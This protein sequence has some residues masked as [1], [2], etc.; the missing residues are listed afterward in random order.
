MAVSNVNVKA[1]R[2]GLLLEH[3]DPDEFW[4]REDGRGYCRVVGHDRS[5]FQHVGC[6][7]L[8]LEHGYRCQWHA[9]SVRGIASR[10][11]MRVRGALQVACDTDAPG[12]IGNATGFKVHTCEV[13]SA[14]CTVDDEVG[15]DR[16]CLPR[17]L[18]RDPKS[19]KDLHHAG[20]RCATPDG[21]TGGCTA[22]QKTFV[23][24]GIKFFQWGVAAVDNHGGASRTC[25]DVR[26]FEGHEAT[27]DERD[28]GWQGGEIQKA[29]AV[30]EVLMT[31]E[32]K[33]ARPG[34]G[35]DEEFARLIGPAIDVDV[36][37][38]CECRH[39]MKCG[40]AVGAKVFFHV[41]RNGVGEAVFVLH[42]VGPVDAEL[43]A[44]DAFTGE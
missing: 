14:T 8:R 7:D 39:T 44:V 27:A 40:H 30:D 15:I 35:G 36:G 28:P 43:I 33:F 37:A 6:G 34:A 11:D 16:G 4:N 25:C 3:A 17:I 22:L 18:H 12:A 2:Y 23:E 24:V 26:E 19:L 38:V 1:V 42:Q 29:G 31:G 32:V 9:G 5:R 21:H 13:R 10:I 41:V 20:D